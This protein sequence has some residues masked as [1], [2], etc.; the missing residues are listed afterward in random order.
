MTMSKTLLAVTG[1][2]MAVT[3]ASSWSE[4]VRYRRIRAM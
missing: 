2:L 1:V 4:L 3:I